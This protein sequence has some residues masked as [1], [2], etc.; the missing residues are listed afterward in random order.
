M[1]PMK[2]YQDFAPTQES[3]QERI[4]PPDEF[5]AAMGRIALG[6]SFLEDTTRNLIVLLSRTDRGTG[7]TL[8]AQLSFRQKMDVLQSLVSHDLESSTDEELK[9]QIGEMFVLSRRAAELRNSYLHS[10]Y[11]GT[12]RAKFS[13]RSKRGL[14]VI[15]EQVSPALL[16]DVADF[17]VYAAM[18][19]EGIPMVLGYAD[20]TRAGADHVSYL[21][22]DSVVATF[23][24]GEVE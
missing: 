13:A 5:D 2:H 17:I 15:K 9:E 8:V 4:G 22:G 7:Y 11:A 24:F 12:L 21:K 19:I 6:F 3:F 10:S 18:E 1:A 14:T 16:L 23:R 20:S